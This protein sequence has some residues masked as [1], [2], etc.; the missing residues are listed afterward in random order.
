MDFNNEI[1]NEEFTN[2]KVWV[3]IFKFSTLTSL[4]IMVNFDPNS[5][6]KIFNLAKN[7][8][9]SISMKLSFPNIDIK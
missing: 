2:D 6:L 5:N 3:V 4:K 9:K 8:F 7:K 1:I